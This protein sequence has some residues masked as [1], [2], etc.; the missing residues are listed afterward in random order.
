MQ[1]KITGGL[2][3][4]GEIRFRYLYEA[5]RLGTMRA[6]SEKL[7]VAT[8]SISRQIAALEKELGMRL[9]EGGRRKIKLTEAGN[10]AFAYYREMR[11]HEEV[12][13]SRVEE[14]RSLRSGTINLAVGEAF[15]SDAFSEVLQS[16]MRKYPG[17]TVRVKMSGTNNAI[18]LVREDEA[19]FGLIFD[20]PRDPKVRARLTL[21]QP[22]K[23]IVHPKHELAG[24]KSVKLSEL[25]QHS[26]GLP[27]DSFRLRQIVREAEHVDGVFL[28]P[29]LIANSMMLLKDFAKCGRGLTFLPE[30]LAQPHLSE[31]KLIA[32]PVDNPVMSST[33]ISLITRTGRQLPTGVYRL[34]LRIEAHLKSLIAPSA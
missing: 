13:L 14:L 26:I 22:L 12:F 31:G 23:A 4:H 5:A 19:H 3:M 10:A 30:F 6:A 18:E 2:S 32:I 16:F 1:R 7:N 28:Q 20:V 33:R 29:G 34:M 15:I 11:A 27:E 8:S 25:G 21:S 17:L 24:R 9:I